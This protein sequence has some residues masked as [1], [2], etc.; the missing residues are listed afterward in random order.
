M[1]EETTELSQDL[2]FQFLMRSLNASVS[3]HLLDEHFTLVAAN[4]R[5]YQMFGYSREEYE[6]LY[7][8]RP[9][10]FYHDSPEDWQ[11]L[12]DIVMDTIKQGK[13]RYECICR[14]KHRDGRKLWIQLVGNFIDEYVN[15]SQVSYSV[16]QDIT[17]IMQ[18]KIEK[19]A[20]ENNFPGS[21]GKYLVTQD[22]YLYLESNRHFEEYL[23]KCLLLPIEQMNEDNGLASL[24]NMHEVLRSGKEATF[25]ISPYNATGERKYLNINV[26]CIDWIN[27]EPVVLFL[28]TD[29]TELNNQKQKLLEYNNSLHKLAFLDDVTK[30][31]NRRKFDLTVSK[32]IPQYAPNT[33]SMI[34][35]NIQKFK[36]INEIGGVEAGDKALKYIH[37]KICAHLHKDEYV[38]RLF[39]DNFIILMKTQEAGSIRQRLHACVEDINVYNEDVDYK[40]YLTFTAGIYAINEPNLLVTSMEDRAHAARKNVDDNNSDLLIC[41]DYT[42]MIRTKM[43]DDK[44]IENRMRVALENNEFEV[45]LQPKYSLKRNKIAGAEALVRWNHPKRGFLPP[46]E[47]IPVFESNGFIIQ[48][49]LY[50]FEKVCQLMQRWSKEGKELLPISVNMSRMHFSKNRFLDDY[51]KTKDRYGVSEKLLEIELTE[52]LVFENPEVFISI[53]Q[54]IHEAGFSCSMDDFGSGYSTLNTLKDLEVDAIKLDGAFFSSKNMENDKENIIVKSVV[55][56]A[57]SLEMAT[58][59]EGIETMSQTD[60]L[61]TVSCD[62]IQGFVFSKPLPIE[63]F[64]KLVVEHQTL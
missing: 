15:G 29:I 13:T 43:L 36:V 12:N 32:V 6:K 52:T 9:D 56:L 18:T 34:W 59:A 62:L 57:N 40:Y 2:E 31:F 7:H 53:I 37:D 1:L 55:D 11:A 35:M 8:N 60:F 28:C 41:N 38:A 10:L 48:L 16:M 22:G 49:D 14:M 27:K 5:Y 44:D 17:D 4:E 24:A 20:T 30:G 50:V 47:F 25:M 26:Q 58:V 23:K 39:S 54:Q 51:I 19:D 21:I 63:E 3:K 42:E 64:E 33:Y 61:R 46:S 45:Y